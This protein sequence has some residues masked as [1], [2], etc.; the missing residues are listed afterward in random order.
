M[1]AILTKKNLL[2]GIRTASHAISGRTALPILGHVLLS[3]EETTIRVSATDH[4]IGVSTVIPAQIL[5]PGEV[6]LPASVAAEVVGAFPE[7]DVIVESDDISNQV[8]LCC[9]P[10]EFNLVGLPPGDFPDL[11]EVPDDVWFEMDA[12]QLRAGLKRTVFACS[13]DELRTILLGVL[14]NFQ[15]DSLGLVA[16]DTH[17]LAVDTRMVPAGEG[18]ASAVVP[19]RAINELL[20]IMPV[21]G[22]VRVHISERQIMFR[23]PEATLVAALIEGQFPNYERVIPTEFDKRWVIPT[24]L[25]TGAVRRASIVARQ[26]MQR[27]VFRSRGEKV[28]VS[29]R[30]GAIGQVYEE[31]EAVREGDDLEIAFN[32]GYLMDVLNVIETD[33]VAFEMSQSLSPAVLKPVGLDDYKCV[34]MPMQVQEAGLSDY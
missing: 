17:R 32:C 18:Q 21:E 24:E 4:Q 12:K 33:G 14:F 2:E 30:A 26:D 7:A 3:S 16:T 15:G 6:T 34:V 19:Q 5:A 20:K 22:T 29:A 27:V 9:P 28:A 11:P 13:T 10:A 25:L 31:V 8:R 1:K 23:L